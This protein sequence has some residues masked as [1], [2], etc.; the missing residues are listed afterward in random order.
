MK[1][2]QFRR[3]HR[4][5]ARTLLHFTAALAVITAVIITARLADSMAEVFNQSTQK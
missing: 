4:H 5:P 2:H 1:P 3:R